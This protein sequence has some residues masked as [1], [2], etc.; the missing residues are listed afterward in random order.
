LLSLARE[1]N[2]GTW[3]REF[4]PIYGPFEADMGRFVDLSKNDFIGRDGAAK[5]KE[6]GPKRS[7]V[8]FVVEAS[9]A[10]AIGDEAVWKDG[11][12]V[13]W[14]TSGGYCHFAEKSLAIGYVPTETI[15]NGGA[16]AKWEVEILGERR[17]ARLQLEP[18]VDP[19]AKRM[20][21]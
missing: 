11:K 9:D 7:R 18:L 1:K 10:D 5:E 8:S 16:S 19:E 6:E 12:V 14:I 17:P 15:A 20:R 13:G 21:G 3:A 2:F 4:R